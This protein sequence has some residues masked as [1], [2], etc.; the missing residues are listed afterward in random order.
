MQAGPPGFIRSIARAWAIYAPAADDDVIRRLAYA[1]D[2]TAEIEDEWA[3]RIIDLA[4]GRSVGEIVDT[5]YGEE[6]RAGAWMADIGIW[7]AHYAGSVIKVVLDLADR[8]YIQLR[9]ASRS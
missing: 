7:S 4:D 6:L 8:G 3:Q 2:D 5:L 1:A 9:D